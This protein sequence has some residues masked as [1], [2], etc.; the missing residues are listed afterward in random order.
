M[1]KLNP[2]YD[3]VETKIITIIAQH[4]IAAISFWRRVSLLSAFQQNKINHKQR[5]RNKFIL[6][7]VC[8]GLLF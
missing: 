3:S 7:G 1:A 4:K 2:K 6:A 8:V 5:Q